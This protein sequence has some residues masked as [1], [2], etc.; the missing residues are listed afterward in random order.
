MVT[1]LYERIFPIQI[2]FRIFSSVLQESRFRIKTTKTALLFSPILSGLFKLLD[3]RI[4]LHGALNDFLHLKVT[5]YFVV[6]PAPIIEL[7]SHK[8]TTLG[9]CFASVKFFHL[10][11]PNFH[12][13]CPIFF[14]TCFHSS[15]TVVKVSYFKLQGL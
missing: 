2:L 12:F 7:H 6:N 14:S 4:L 8:I 3:L 11:V 9:P 15:I 5:I 13:S 10:I 1:F